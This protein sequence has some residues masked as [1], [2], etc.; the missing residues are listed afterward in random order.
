MPETY[1]HLDRAG[2]LRENQVLVEPRAKR[3]KDVKFPPLLEPL[4]PGILSE[5]GRAYVAE[6]NRGKDFGLELVFEMV[7]VEQFAN[8]PSRLSS[9]FC[10]ASPTDLDMFRD[11]NLPIRP[12]LWEISAEPAFSFDIGWVGGRTIFDAYQNAVHYWSGDP[13]EGDSRFRGREYLVQYPATV[14]RI[15]G[16]P[17]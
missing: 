17:T 12:V 6:G 9:L 5:H 11:P 14:V 10:A 4:V 7:R 13:Y 8:L 2:T 15:V 3:R 1:F 16:V